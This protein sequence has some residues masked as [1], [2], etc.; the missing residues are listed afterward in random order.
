[1]R[2]GPAFVNEKGSSCL[3][4]MKGVTLHFGDKTLFDDLNL[5]VQ[6]GES[7]V[8]LSPTGIGKRS[9]LRLLVETLHP[10]RGSILF[11]GVEITHL[12]ENS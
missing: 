2:R 4:E 1:M 11:D 9:L 7:L 5:V 8:L 12:P 3:V 10:E 6:Y